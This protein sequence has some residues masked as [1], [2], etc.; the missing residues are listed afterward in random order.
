MIWI[1]LKIGLN[2]PK[3][4]FLLVISLPLIIIFFFVKSIVIFATFLP[5]RRS[6]PTAIFLNGRADLKLGKR[7]RGENVNEL[8]I[9]VLVCCIIIIIYQGSA[10]SST[11]SLGNLG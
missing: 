8:E 1:W 2:D 4:M 10:M 3:K 9:G 11:V 6:D 5:D 7:S